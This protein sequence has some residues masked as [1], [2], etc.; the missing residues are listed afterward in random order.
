[1]GIDENFKVDAV[2]EIRETMINELAQSEVNENLLKVL[3]NI[4]N[5]TIIDALTRDNARAWWKVYRGY[6]IQHAQLIIQ[7]TLLVAKA[8]GAES[9]TENH[10]IEGADIIIREARTIC[11]EGDK[12]RHGC[13]KYW[14]RASISLDRY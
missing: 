10:L 14:G 12:N 8:R 4:L 5:V 6:M 3:E 9:V 2:N 11:P 13:G 7:A 1:M